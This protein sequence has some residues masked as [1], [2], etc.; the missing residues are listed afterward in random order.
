MRKIH[1]VLGVFIFILATSGAFLLGVH[2]SN[3]TA[4]DMVILL[5]IIF[6]FYMI[7]IAI[8]YHS[9]YL[10]YLH[11]FVDTKEQKRATHIL[12]AYLL[13]GGYWLIASISAI[14]LFTAVFTQ[15]DDGMLKLMLSSGLFGLTAL[16]IFFVLLM[17]RQ[18]ING[19]VG[20]AKSM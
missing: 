12:R 4:Q 13:T 10:K 7:S 5:S 1:K 9:P 15:D 14:I 3:A 8:F 19:I 11:A 2:I 16:N 17:M 20:A 18:A 6:G